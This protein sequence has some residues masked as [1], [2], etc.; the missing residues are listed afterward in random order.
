M[1]VDPVAQTLLEHLEAAPVVPTLLWGAGLLPAKR[2]APDLRLLSWD[3]RDARDHDD[4]LELG[5]LPAAGDARRIV[6]RLPRSKPELSLRIRVA[7]AR[8]GEGDEI[9]LVGA[10]NEGIRSVGKLLG[11]WFGAPTT[12]HL[13]R[14]CRVMGAWRN[15]EPAVEPTLESLVETFETPTPDGPLPCASLPG[16]F[17]HGRPD[18]GTARL[19]EA[20][21]QVKGFHAALD[22][23]A[24][25]GVLG[26]FLARRRRKARVD[27][28]DVSAIACESA[29]RTLALSGLSQA[30]VH[31]AAAVDAPRVKYDLIVTNPPFHDVRGADRSMVEGFIRAARARMQDRGALWLVSNLHLPYGKLLSAAFAQLETVAE[32]R[33]FRVFS[34]RR[35]R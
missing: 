32:D 35:P 30:R 34:A 20:L 4:A 26:A 2:A 21:D 14:R 25:C 28:V 18:A 27:L 22:L 15:A 16:T 11:P 31:H 29:R 7:A 5:V 19:L 1:A 12:L 3:A 23:G 6:I 8:L 17:S 13:K 10:K 9:W 24:G 33:H